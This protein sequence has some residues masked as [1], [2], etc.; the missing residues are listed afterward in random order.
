MLMT[1][2]AASLTRAMHYGIELSTN[3]WRAQPEYVF[4]RTR[5]KIVLGL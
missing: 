3:L 4:R 2:T 1:K 5:V